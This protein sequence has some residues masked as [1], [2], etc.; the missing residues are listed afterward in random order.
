MMTV[1]KEVNG[2]ACRRYQERPRGTKARVWRATCTRKHVQGE[3]EMPGHSVLN[4]KFDDFLFAPIGEETNKM[5]LSVLSALTRLGV[6]PRQEA[7]RLAQL[8][9]ELA[10]QSLA[11]MIG[12]PN[13]RWAPSDS[14]VI[15]ARL[16][17]LLPPGVDSNAPFIVENRSVRQMIRFL[18]V[19]WLICAAA[20]VA[21]LISANREPPSGTNHTDTPPINA[22]SAPETHLLDAD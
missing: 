15:A 19:T 17:E 4:S 1:G 21:L 5:I 10:T 12:R 6:D 14:R 20:L 7:G 22:V 8:P 2:A 11:S 16:V 18:P 3:R 13:G 9:R